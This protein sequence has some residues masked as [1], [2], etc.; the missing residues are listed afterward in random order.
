MNYKKY[1]IISVDELDKVRMEELPER[2]HDDLRRSLDGSKVLI[3]WWS[4]DCKC[5]FP[6][7]E[8]PVQANSMDPE[9][10][11]QP[12]ATTPPD[13]NFIKSLETAEGPYT[14]SEILSILSTS[15]WHRDITNV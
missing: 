2:S 9:S 3:R 11:V 4:T 7:I 15:E 5:W 14:H 8:T 1:L 6:S 12:E 10:Y 13:P